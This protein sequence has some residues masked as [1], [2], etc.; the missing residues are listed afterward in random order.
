MSD[1]NWKA[2]RLDVKP[3]S[4]PEQTASAV[5]KVL[6][7]FTFA[8]WTDCQQEG[9]RIVANEPHSPESITAV[10]ATLRSLAETLPAV[11]TVANGWAPAD[12]KFTNRDAMHSAVD[13]LRKY[14]TLRSD[15]EVAREK[16]RSDVE[17]QQR[18]ALTEKIYNQGLEDGKAA[19][20][21]RAKEARKGRKRGAKK[22]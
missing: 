21:M 11:L 2:A 8:K 9:R 18:H 12:I 6:D 14:Y 17:S 7:E 19:E 3:G 22:P 10:I 5:R 20:Q 15:Q 16:Q 13:M 4:T 1:A